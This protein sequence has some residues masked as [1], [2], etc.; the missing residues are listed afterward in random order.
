M[1]AVTVRVAIIAAALVAIVI[2]AIWLSDAHRFV[3]AQSAA[4]AARTPAQF[5]AAA[6][7]FE[8]QT[9]LTPHTDA[10]AAQAFSLLRA[11]Q[12]P[13][14]EALLED[15]IRTEPRNVRVWASLY[16]ADRGRKPARAAYAK[17]RIRALAPPVR[18]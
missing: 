1:A 11:G 2:S 3:G 16:F 17:A 15:V 8:G 18:P 13:Q 5:E 6:K 14:A 10:K 7:R 4:N 12:R 9:A